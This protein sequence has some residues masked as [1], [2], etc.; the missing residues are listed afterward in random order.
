[1]TTRYLSPSGN[2]ANPGTYASPF[3]TGT[4]AV[5]ASSA[6]DT[7]IARAGTYRDA[8]EIDGATTVPIWVVAII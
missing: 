5:A 8:F 2:D 7:I 6:G 3:L 4:A 1:M